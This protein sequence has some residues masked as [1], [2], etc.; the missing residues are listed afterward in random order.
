MAR[1]KGSVRALFQSV[2]ATWTC[3]PAPLLPC[4]PPPLSCS[5]PLTL[6]QSPSQ[7]CLRVCGLIFVTHHPCFHLL[8]PLSPPITR[9]HLS[10]PLAL[11]CF[12]LLS[13]LP[14]QITTV[15]TSYHFCLLPSP[16]TPPITRLILTSPLFLWTPFPPDFHSVSSLIQPR[17]TPVSPPFQ[18]PTPPFLLP[19]TS[20][21]FPFPFTPHFHVSLLIARFILVSPFLILTTPVFTS[22]VG[23][24][25]S[26]QALFNRVPNSEAYDH[27]CFNLVSPVSW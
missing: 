8:S 9:F 14:P 10:S 7:L 20:F 3:H 15:S 16:L 18:P 2:D 21:H 11:P 17:M 23:L 19:M 12:N 5:L 6:V 1:E 25:I 13:L 27:P 4:S 26:F 22:I 24:Y